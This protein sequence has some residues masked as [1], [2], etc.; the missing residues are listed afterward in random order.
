MAYIK[1]NPFQITERPS[2]TLGVIF[3]VIDKKGNR[4]KSFVS[5]ELAEHYSTQQFLQIQFDKAIKADKPTGVR[6][7]LKKVYGE[8]LVT[9]IVLDL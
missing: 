2:T 7:D 5:A 9:E 3:D 1:K 6:S 4:L 8:D